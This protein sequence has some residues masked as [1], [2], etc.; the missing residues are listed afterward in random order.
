[1]TTMTIA[2]R[3][4]APC[5]GETYQVLG[6]QVTFKALAADTAGG[7][8]L[9][10]LLT[11][12]GAGSAPHLQHHEDEAFFVLEGTYSALIGEERVDLG[13]GSY[14]FVPRGTVHAL[15]NI[16]TGVARMLIMVTPGGNHERF[17]TEIGELVEDPSRYTP[18]LPVRDSRIALAAANYGVEFFADR[19]DHLHAA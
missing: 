5:V 6:E 13:P 10:E 11:A 18:G 1:M 15:T 4:V 12:P 3:R 8:T 9:F 19:E 16:G 17:L 14:V 7:Y 2:P